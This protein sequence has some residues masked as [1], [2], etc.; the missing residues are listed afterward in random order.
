MKHDDG[1]VEVAARVDAELFSYLSAARG[2]LA[3]GAPLITE[4]ETL[5]GAGGKRLRPAFCYWGYRAGGGEDGAPI[6][7]VAASLEL[8]HTFALVHDDVMD[9]AEL[10]R[11]APTVHARRG[12]DVAILV[13]NLALV[14]ADSA[15][16]ESGFPSGPLLEAFRV[17]SRMRREVIA[18]QYLD[19]LLSRE[20]SVSEEEARRVAVLKSGR[21]SVAEPL[22]IGAVLAGT[23]NEI[24]DGLFAFGEYVG[25]AFQLR[26]DLLGLFGDEEL[27]GK[28]AD[29]DVRGGKKH[30]LFAKTVAALEEPDRAR[31]LSRWGGGEELSPADVGAVRG[32][33]ER[34]GAREATEKLASDLVARALEALAALD[35]AGDARDALADLAL[36]AAARSR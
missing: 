20:D 12:V 23:P 8:L 10:R 17:Y 13:G 11:G 16:L 14:L 1:A 24:V 22:S 21:Y 29:S 9:G 25:E 4:I 5:I 27:T 33:V 2:A 7:R 32:L 28:P 31:F 36:G 18:G 3:E 15:F 35:I 19:L 34:S 30:V 6:W 26:D